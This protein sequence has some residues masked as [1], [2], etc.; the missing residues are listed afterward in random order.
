MAQK[1]G[2]GFGLVLLLTGVVTAIGVSTLQ[3]IERRF[4]L[5]KQMSEINRMVLRVRLHEQAF[6]LAGDPAEADGLRT[7]IDAILGVT[8]ALKTE[9]GAT[10]A[11]MG[12]VEAAVNAYRASFDEFVDVTQ[13]KQRALETAA[14]SVQNVTNNLDLVRSMFVEDGLVLL[15]SSQGKSGA[16]LVEHAGQ[17][18]EGSRLVLQA[19]NEAH[20]RLEQ[21]RKAAGT[22]VEGGARIAQS[23]EALGRIKQLIDAAGND[24]A[25]RSVL[26]EAVSHITAFDDRLAEYTD[27]L[28]KERKVHVQMIERAEQVM[29]RVDGAYVEQD[30]AMRQELG[31]SAGSILA[32]SLVALLAGLAAAT[33]ITRAVVRPLR[34]VIRVA[35][36]IA[37]G[38]LTARIEVHGA[39]EVGQLM[40][41]MERMSAAL[42]GI[43][44]GLQAGIGKIAASAQTLSTA[45]ERTNVEVGS[46]KLETE[47]V[48]TAMNE[49]VQ[50][51]EEVARSAED[52][53]SAAESADAR[54]QSGREAVTA[55][56]ARFEQLA[57][58]A[59]AARESMRSLHQEVQNIGAV[60]GVIKG[61]AEQT[62]RL[63]LNAAIEAARAGEQGR[64]FAVVAD[65]V[66]QLAQRTQQSTAEIEGLMLVLLESA[67]DSVQQIGASSEL[68]QTTV[69]DARQTE[70]VLHSI[71]EAVS[72]I[73][74]MNR[75]IATVAEQQSSVAAEVNRSVASI[76][77]SADQSAAAMEGTAA[78]SVELAQLSNT[79]QGMVGQF[80]I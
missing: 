58:A 33:L 25:Y 11:V 65:E 80:R 44:G 56:M 31:A 18:G 73:H 29:R 60:L 22:R 14:W 47:Q 72:V 26:A 4:D 45:A 21:S 1:L 43:V 79:L 20:V 36:R 41:A 57:A 3:G 6:S 48:A 30:E 71:A 59:G 38:D 52:A 13:S 9:S 64:G 8:A 28:A 34:S 5:L 46:Q 51:V 2:V 12:E 63:A 75:Q 67:R 42:G 7:R 62:N 32:S 70:S 16:A 10:A 37:D 15:N 40:R 61:L 66:R 54:V 74:R 77:G 17:L 39:D 68:V 24:T 35:D 78:S 53:A 27:L 50:S 49:M 55:S 23:E 69:A 19:M 76:R